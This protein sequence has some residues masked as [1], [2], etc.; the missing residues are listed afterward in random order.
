MSAICT[1]KNRVPTYYSNDQL[2]ADELAHF[3]LFI[4]NGYPKQMVYRILYM[5]KK[6][7]RMVQEKQ[8]KEQID[9]SNTY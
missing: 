3:E 6:G 7:D 9:F 8:Q 5:E 1:L 2:L 4:Q